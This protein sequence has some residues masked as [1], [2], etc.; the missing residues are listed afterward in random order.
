M[1]PR[2]VLAL[3]LI[4]A[5]AGCTDEDPGA[6]VDTQSTDPGETGASPAANPSSSAPPRPA[7]PTPTPSPASASTPAT[8][9]SNASAPA[10]PPPNVVTVEGDAVATL[11]VGVPQPVGAIGFLVGYAQLDIP[12]PTPSNA[13]FVATWT[14]QT[15][16]DASMDVGLFD[17]DGNSIALASGASPLT[18]GIPGE[19]FG[20]ATEIRAMASP[21]APGAGVEYAVHVVL[22]VNYA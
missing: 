15:P 7:S 21:T 9:A 3:V 1:R 13:T 8:N 12:R 5:A 18:L 16:L 10:P 17:T 22:T 20:A 6:T 19:A 14:S 4:A 2:I 11:M